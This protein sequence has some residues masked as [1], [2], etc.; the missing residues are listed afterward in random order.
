MVQCV[1]EDAWIIVDDLLGADEHELRLHWLMPDL[2]FAVTAGSPFCAVLSAENVRFRWNVFS[3]SP[4]SAAIIRAGKN[5]AT[6]LACRDRDQ[7]QDEELLGWESPTY[8]ELRPAISLVYHVQAPLP[9]RIV[10]VILA[11][12]ALRL[13]QSDSNLVLSRDAAQVYQVSLAP[14]PIDRASA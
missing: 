9:V 1:A 4:G 10:T 5:V 13:R 3:S 6:G 8:G 7:D 14:V 12:E 2:P 11:G